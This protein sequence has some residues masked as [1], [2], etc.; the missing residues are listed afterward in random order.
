MVVGHDLDPCTKVPKHATC[1]HPQYSRGRAILV[2][3]P[4]LDHTCTPDSEIMERILSWM[5]S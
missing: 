4:G 5:T 1:F 2:D 3:T